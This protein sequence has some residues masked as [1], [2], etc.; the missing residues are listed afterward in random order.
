MY[1]YC[2]AISPIINVCMLFEAKLVLLL[3]T[4][5]WTFTS[6]SRCRVGGDIISS[7]RRSAKWEISFAV[8]PC[9]S[10][11]RQHSGCVM[12]GDVW[13]F[14]SIFTGSWSTNLEI[15]I[16]LTSLSMWLVNLRCFS[17]VIQTY[18]TV[19][20]RSR[21]GGAS[22]C[23]FSHKCKMICDFRDLWVCIYL[24]CLILR[25]YLNNKHHLAEQVWGLPSSQTWMQPA[26]R[27]ENHR[28]RKIKCWRRGT[29][30]RMRG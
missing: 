12:L 30:W 27:E 24:Y 18:L 26:E 20:Q 29:Q 28:A 17:S 25:W 4:N 15:W 14:L 19:M 5:D 16:R 13:F 2:P 1:L 8:H 22:L 7:G 9:L 3:E 11:L 23:L 21:K 10:V 6:R